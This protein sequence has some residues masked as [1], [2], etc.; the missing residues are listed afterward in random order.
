MAESVTITLPR[1]VVNRTI[2]KVLLL[3]IVGCLMGGF[4]AID[5]AKKAEM[6][7][8]LTLEQY[9]AGFDQHR[10]ALM[11][12]SMPTWASILVC[13][14]IALAA[15]GV[16]ELLGGLLGLVVG[17]IR[18]EGITDSSGPDTSGTTST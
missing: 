8:Q 7:E 1:S 11:R 12:P 17:K 9:T 3:V 18:G 4:F 5:Q 16:Y 2:G 6:G 13:L 10:A 15:A 14:L